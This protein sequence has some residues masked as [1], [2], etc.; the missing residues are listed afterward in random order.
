MVNPGDGG[1]WGW[2]TLGIAT[3][4]DSGPWRWRSSGMAD[5]GDGVP[6]D[7]GLADPGMADPGDGGPEPIPLFHTKFATHPSKK[8]GIC[9]IGDYMTRD[10]QQ[11]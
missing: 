10:T 8:V 4:G 11:N 7:G 9:G 1:P 6:W 2:R 3:P 5:P